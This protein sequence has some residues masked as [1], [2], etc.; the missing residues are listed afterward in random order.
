MVLLCPSAHE[1]DT[2]LSVSHMQLYLSLS[3]RSSLL[4]SLLVFIDLK[5]EELLDYRRA[6]LQTV[7][8]CCKL[9]FR[10]F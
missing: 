7:T 8:A 4:N 1:M 3:P 5:R 2:L 9:A 6:V 10:R